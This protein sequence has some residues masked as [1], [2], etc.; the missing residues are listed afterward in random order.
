[1]F[2]FQNICFKFLKIYG[3]Q[4]AFQGSPQ[5]VGISLQNYTLANLNHCHLEP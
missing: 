3:L 5:D 2:I 1:M 4:S